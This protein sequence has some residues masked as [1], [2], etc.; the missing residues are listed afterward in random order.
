MKWITREKVKVANTILRSF[1][2]YIYNIVAAV[3]IG[4]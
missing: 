2:R 3:P 4:L 1:I